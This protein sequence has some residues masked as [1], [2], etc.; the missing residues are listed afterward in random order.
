MVIP[1]GHARGEQGSMWRCNDKFRPVI[2]GETR[3]A[4]EDTENNL[5][6]AGDDYKKDKLL[7]TL[8]SRWNVSPRNIEYYGR[9]EIHMAQSNKLPTLDIY[10]DRQESNPVSPPIYTVVV[11]A[12]RIRQGGRVDGD[13]ETSKT[14]RVWWERRK[15]NWPKLASL[16]I[17]GVSGGGG[18]GGGDGGGAIRNAAV[19]RLPPSAFPA[20]LPGNPP[21]P[22]FFSPFLLLPRQLFRS[23]R[24]MKCALYEEIPWAILRDATNM[25]C[26]PL[27]NRTIVATILPVSALV[28]LL[29]NNDSLYTPSSSSPF[30]FSSDEN[31]TPGYR[32]LPSAIHKMGSNARFFLIETHN[33]IARNRFPTSSLN[34]SPFEKSLMPARILTRW[35][36]SMHPIV[37]IPSS[38]DNREAEI[39]RSTGKTG[40]KRSRRLTS[41]TFV[42]PC[43]ARIHGLSVDDPDEIYGFPLGF[44]SGA[45]TVFVVVNSALRLEIYVVGDLTLLLRRISPF[46]TAFDARIFRSGEI[47]LRGDGCGTQSG[48]RMRCCNDTIC[49]TTERAQSWRTKQTINFNEQSERFRFLHFGGLLLAED[50]G[51]FVGPNL[52]KGPIG[53]VHSSTTTATRLLFLC[54]LPSVYLHFAARAGCNSGA[55]ERDKLPGSFVQFPRRNTKQMDYV[56]EVESGINKQNAEG[57]AKGPERRPVLSTHCSSRRV[58]ICERMVKTLYPRLSRGPKLLFKAYQR[59][60]ICKFTIYPERNDLARMR[61][62]ASSYPRR[63]LSG[64]NSAGPQWDSNKFNSRA[65]RRAGKKARRP[66]TRRAGGR[67][68]GGGTTRSTGLHG[69]RSENAFYPPSKGKVG[70]ARG[71]A[72]IHAE[73]R[74]RDFGDLEE[75]YNFR[76]SRT[77]ELNRERL[78]IEDSVEPTNR[79]EIGEKL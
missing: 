3:T 13:Q 28:S 25:E 18:D 77:H 39:A 31:S 2:T 9:F 76:N 65:P 72:C 74:F 61:E 17:S 1:S 37:G 6:I 26:F 43:A 41:V 23:S 64:V 22:H 75:E 49:R 58:Y 52:T 57:R 36:I 48:L 5:I 71:G 46:A 59:K 53:P 56:K 70:G 54:V 15:P 38:R 66:S 69:W 63:R 73:A 78:G 19:K 21:Y 12:A 50:K 35:N 44:L 51:S 30:S 68:G 60:R 47:R 67:R 24:N 7:A 29:S 33:S 14:G 55:E 27:E 45:S 34:S 62:T 16:V 79:K 11:S 32:I 40:N 10:G 20:P 4:L 42:K 8:I